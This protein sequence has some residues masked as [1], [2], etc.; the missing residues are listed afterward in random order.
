MARLHSKKK[1]KSSSKFAG[2]KKS[3]PAFAQLNAEEA[4]DIVKKLFR[5]G[6]STANIGV[7]LRDQYGVPS[8]KGLT[9]VSMKQFLKQEKIY[10]KMPEDML[11]LIRKAVRL[12]EHLKKN[13]KDIANRVKYNHILSKI[14]RLA[15]YYK[16][17]GEISATWKYDPEEAAALI[18]A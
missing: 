14:N 4:K 3:S 5:Q 12:W 13:K 15:S 2:R 16:K 9:G 17:K 10:T 18:R 7:I 6:N 1:G 8:F 11:N